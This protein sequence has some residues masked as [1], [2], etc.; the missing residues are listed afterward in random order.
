M[1]ITFYHHMSPKKNQDFSKKSPKNSQTPNVSQ[2]ITQFRHLNFPK[3]TSMAPRLTALGRGSG[4]W[5]QAV[6]LL[7]KA[8]EALLWDF[9]GD[10]M[11]YHRN[12]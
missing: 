3:K 5:Q 2:T 1:F 9:Y 11:G 10:N 7:E 8:L 12:L 6:W 4:P